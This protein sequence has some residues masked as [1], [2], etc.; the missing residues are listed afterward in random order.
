MVGSTISHYKIIDKLGAGGMGE[1]Y[2]AEDTNLSRHVA[3]KL[4]PDNFSSDPERMARFEREAKLLASLNHPNIAA[5]YGLEQGEGKRFIVMELVEGDTLAQKL[6]KGPLPVEETLVLCSQIAEGLE[7]AHEKGVIHR[8]LKPANVMITKGDN[9]KILDFG[10]AKALSDETQRVDSSQLPT[11]TEAMTQP[12]VILGTAAYMSP[13]QAKGK[14]VDKRADIW[15]F[16]CILYECLT[17]KKAFEGETVTETLASVLTR[18]PGW[19]RIPAQV[20]PLLYRCLEKDPK[21]RLRDIGDG[22]PLLEGLAQS[23]QIRGGR[24]WLAWSVSAV[25]IVAFAAMSLIHFREKPLAQAEFTRFQIGFPEKISPGSV[26]AFALS[27]NGRH[28]AFAGVGSDGAAR[29]WLRSL[30]SLEAHPLAGTES[31][32]ALPPFFWSPDSRFIVFD[33][34]GKLKKVEISGGPPQPICDLPDVAIGGSWNGDGTIVFGASSRGIMKI[35][36]SGGIVSQLTKPNPARQETGHAFPVFLPDGRHFLYFCWSANP[37]NTGIY[38][39]SLDSK[40]EEHDSKLLI[41]TM[42]DANYVPSIDSSSGYLLFLHGN[43]LMAQL[44]DD[45]QL[46][47]KGDPVPVAESVEFSLGGRF[48]V[49]TNG[50]LIYRQQP[51]ENQLTWID[52]VGR[53]LA[54]IG[55]PGIYQTFDLSKDAKQLVVSK[56]EPDGWSQNLWLIDLLRG[57]ITRLTKEDVRHD[58]PRWSRDGGQVIFVS[59]SDSKIIFQLSLPTGKPMKV[60]E[61]GSVYCG[62]DDWSPDGRYLLYHKGEPEL[63]VLPLAGNGKPMLIARSLAGFVDQARF[64]PDGRWIAYN[65]NESG[66][67]EVK[68]VAFPPTDDKWQIST[69]GGVQPTWRGDGCELYFLSLDGT[70]MSVDVQPGTRFQFGEPSRLFKSQL[71]I[72]ESH[73]EQYAPAPNGKRFLFVKPTAESSKPPFNVILNWTALLKK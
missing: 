66:R 17:G 21:K 58:D 73:S 71:S 9:I 41:A 72:I 63:W 40:L 47:L 6:S 49:S 46:R 55:E 2:R 31:D 64:S 53:E 38:V 13:E 3:I 59:M 52:R 30:D 26:G 8:D 19:D 34:G 25:F 62:L 60:F 7:A 23:T 54:V 18:E 44:F 20:R 61:L 11:L 27:P 35:S 29:I 28:L 45:S 33:S 50:T 42:S 57:Q 51:V 14:T 24:R 22:M 39:S 10:L 65:T 67:H 43:T 68:I 70:L 37:T 12:G 36:S 1:V 4:L 5:I 56:A 15:A 16:G 48:S 32:I 69:A